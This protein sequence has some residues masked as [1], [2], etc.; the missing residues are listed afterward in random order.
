[1]VLRRARRSISAIGEQSAW[2]NSKVPGLVKAR[3]FVAGASR[4]RNLRVA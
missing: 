3:V 2:T 1:M 4:D